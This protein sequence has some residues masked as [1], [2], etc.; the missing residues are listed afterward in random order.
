MKLVKLDIRG[1][2]FGKVDKQHPVFKYDYSL[3]LAE[4]ELTDC[5]QKHNCEKN[6]NIPFIYEE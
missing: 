1:C 6:E 3:T 4:R 2:K 5:V